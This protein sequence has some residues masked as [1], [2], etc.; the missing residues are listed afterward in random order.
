[1]IASKYWKLNTAF[2]SPSL[3]SLSAISVHTNRLRLPAVVEI[4]Q[5]ILIT[6]ENIFW[7]KLTSPSTLP[8]ARHYVLKRIWF[9]SFYNYDTALAA[10]SV[11]VTVVVA[12]E[13]NHTAQVAIPIIFLNIFQRANYFL[14]T[15]GNGI[16]PPSSVHSASLSQLVK[17]TWC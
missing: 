9:T 10:Q 12:V 17:R 4:L 5:N 11:R 6:V 8:G 15:L 16:W 1:M 2:T 3:S 13:T 7:Y 14:V